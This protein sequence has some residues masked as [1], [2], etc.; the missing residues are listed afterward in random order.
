MNLNKSWQAYELDQPSYKTSTYRAS[1][2][3]NVENKVREK[4]DTI[5]IT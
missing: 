5:R 3:R 2:N 1:F 4:R